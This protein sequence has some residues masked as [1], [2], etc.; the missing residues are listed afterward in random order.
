[1]NEFSDASGT[2]K[3]D[4]LGRRA[5]LIAHDIELVVWIAEV[6]RWLHGLLGKDG[7]SRWIT[8]VLKSLNR[9]KM[10]YER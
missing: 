6:G 5:V 8:T 7:R 10:E 4:R 9:F 3:K 1:M 2:K